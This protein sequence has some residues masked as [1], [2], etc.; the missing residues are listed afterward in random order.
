MIPG[1]RPEDELQERVEAAL[2]DLLDTFGM[3]TFGEVRYTDE[4][5][6]EAFARL[7]EDVTAFI[8]D[9]QL[10]I[11]SENIGMDTKFVPAVER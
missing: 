3:D 1:N 2:A 8:V 10:E 6:M 5:F 9:H 11:T 7:A 4:P